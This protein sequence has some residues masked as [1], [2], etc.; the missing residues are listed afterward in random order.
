MFW[1]IENSSQLKEF[2]NKGYDEVFIEP[3]CL[4]DS[5][6]PKLTDISLLYIRPIKGRKGFIININHSEATPI[7]KSHLL[8]LL[9]TYKTIYVR[10]QKSSLYHFPIK[11]LVDIAFNYF[12]IKLNPPTP[13]MTP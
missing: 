2:Y 4:H 12:P 1:L 5:V 9:K 11:T 7:S 10:N 3:I 6:H 8:N 13:T